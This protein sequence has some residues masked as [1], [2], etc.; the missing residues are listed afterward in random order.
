MVMQDWD[1]V[2]WCKQECFLVDQYKYH[3]ATS[4]CSECRKRIANNRRWEE[5]VP[6]IDAE[7]E[8]KKANES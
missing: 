6:K 5:L 4:K 2:E 7:R 8:R 3:F 1:T